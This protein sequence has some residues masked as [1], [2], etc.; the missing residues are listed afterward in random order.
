MLRVALYLGKTW[1]VR[2]RAES[3]GVHCA[4][5][6]TCAQLT[7]PCYGSRMMQ[8]S[9]WRR[10]ISE[11]LDRSMPAMYNDKANLN[12]I[13]NGH[14]G[15]ETTSFQVVVAANPLRLWV[16]ARGQPATK[17]IPGRHDRRQRTAK[18]QPPPFADNRSIWNRPCY[19]V[20]VC[21]GQG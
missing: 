10:Q 2:N 6:S 16:I 19:G 8:N 17:S 9:D 12:D 11:R 14:V 5:V 18:H 15:G 1:S 20:H 7:L 13:H 4:S 3:S 21:A